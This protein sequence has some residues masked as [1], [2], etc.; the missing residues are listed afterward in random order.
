MKVA[1]IAGIKQ[2]G[3]ISGLGIGE[4]GS[5][6][7]KFKQGEFSGFAKVLY[8]DNF[9]RRVS[10]QVIAKPAKAKPAPVKK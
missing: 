7:K 8:F 10:R 1:G 5:I 9:G 4:A 3:S 6:L 2:D